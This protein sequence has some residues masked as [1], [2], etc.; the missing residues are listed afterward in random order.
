MSNRSS[1]STV[2]SNR[3]ALE[4]TILTHGV[5]RDNALSLAQ[6][7]AG[8]AQTNGATPA[9]V[10][11]F[12]GEPIVGMSDEQLRE[13]LA[14]P[15]V[16]KVNTSN[17]GVLMHRRSHGSTT[18]ATTMELAAAAGVRVFSTGGIGGVHKGYGT[19]LDIS[20]DLIALTRFPVAVVASGVKSILDVVATRE[21]LETLGVPVVGFGCD[22]FP[23]FYLRSSGAGVDAR[24]DDAGE[25][26][27]FVGAEMRRTGRGVLVANPIPLADEL[28]AARFGEWLAAAEREAKPG[29]EATPSTL[30]ALHRLS[31]GA[32]LR[33]NLALIRSNT[34]LGA[35]LAAALATG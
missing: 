15:N 8:I 7:L 26:A 1:H 29:R 32:T 30:A 11:I 33:A 17:L 19:H 35:R 24:F 34:A 18:V 23:A 28:P 22:E 16:P 12:R 10:G 9:L 14:T 5:P 25:L 27:R 20:A 6:E 21:L 4:T 13:V 31:G 2:P 3:L